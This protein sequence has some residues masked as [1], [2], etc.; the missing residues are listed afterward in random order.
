MLG[1]RTLHRTVRRT[2]CGSTRNS[3][4]ASFYAVPGGHAVRIAL[5]KSDHANNQARASSVHIRRKDVCTSPRPLLLV[6]S[7]ACRPVPIAPDT[8]RSDLPKPS[9]RRVPEQYRHHRQTRFRNGCNNRLAR[10]NSRGVRYGYSKV[11]SRSLRVSVTPARR[12]WPGV[13]ANSHCV[14]LFYVDEVHDASGLGGG[15]IGGLRDVVRR[16][17]VERYTDG[18]IDAIGIN[19]PYRGRVLEAFDLTATNT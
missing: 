5:N 15:V 19:D 9:S 17:A 1:N 11:W 3:V 16:L 6:S 12:S 10:N 4:S 18:S 2:L 8:T 7:M 13:A 14:V